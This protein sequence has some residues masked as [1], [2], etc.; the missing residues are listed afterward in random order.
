MR[1]KQSLNF[2]D[3]SSSLYQK[4]TDQKSLYYIA[5]NDDAYFY[6]SPH[7]PTRR[8]GD[9]RFAHI[10]QGDTIKISEIEGD[11]G[12]GIFTSPITNKTTKGWVP[13]STLKREE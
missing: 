7:W 13:L 2:T 9:Q 1:I 3:D 11:F 6:S 8:N 4:A 5:I 10:A 12:F